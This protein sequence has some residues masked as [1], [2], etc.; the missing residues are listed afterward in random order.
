M[1]FPE[2]RE[3]TK[4]ELAKV[5]ADAEA[6][7]KAERHAEYVQKYKAYLKTKR[8]FWNIVFPFRIHIERI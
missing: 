6:E 2:A 5:M 7:L 1:K 4:I 8:N 3:L